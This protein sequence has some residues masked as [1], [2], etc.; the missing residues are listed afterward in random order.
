[1]A[2]P[3]FFQDGGRHAAGRGVRESGRERESEQENETSAF[4]AIFFFAETA[5]APLG[6][7]AASESGLAAK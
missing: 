7:V 6:L 4:S 2:I 5:A 3:L 1:M